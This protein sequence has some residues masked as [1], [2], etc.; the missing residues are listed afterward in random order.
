MNPS[1]IFRL[2]V[3]ILL[4]LAL[5]V[6]SLAMDVITFALAVPEECRRPESGRRTSPLARFAAQWEGWLSGSRHLIRNCFSPFPHIWPL[7]GLLRYLSR[8]ESFGGLLPWTSA[9]TASRA[10]DARR[11]CILPR[12]ESSVASAAVYLAARLRRASSM[13]KASTQSSCPASVSSPSN[14][15]TAPSD[16]E[17]EN[18]MLASRKTR[19]IQSHRLR[20]FRAFGSTASNA[21]SSSSDSWIRFSP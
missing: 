1:R 2:L 12:S 8:S 4:E 21:A 11:R 7:R 5:S 16:L 13:T 14:R 17:A 15:C 9:G 6:L 18:R 3:A 10:V 19:M 20:C